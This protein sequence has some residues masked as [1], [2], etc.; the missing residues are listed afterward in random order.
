MGLKWEGETSILFLWFEAPKEMSSGQFLRFAATYLI[1][2]QP[3]T[4]SQ[5]S[6]NLWATSV[7][8]TPDDV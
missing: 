2:Q 7:A 5:P 4:S 3:K 6:S 8:S 1:K